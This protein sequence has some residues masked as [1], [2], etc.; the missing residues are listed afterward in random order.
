LRIT[1]ATM[2][3]L[4]GAS[5]VDLAWL[6]RG[7]E[8]L[9]KSLYTVD[10]TMT[11]FHPHPNTLPWPVLLLFGCYSR[12]HQF[13]SAK[14]IDLAKASHAVRE[15]CTRIRWWAHFVDDPD[16][17]PNNTNAHAVKSNGIDCMKNVHGKSSDI[18]PPRADTALQRTVVYKPLVPRGPKGF[19]GRSAPEINAVCSSLHNGFMKHVVQVN[20]KIAHK[21]LAGSN[22]PWYARFAL[23]FI[24]KQNLCAI[25]SDK[26]GVFTILHR[27]TLQSMTSK[28]VNSSKY[29]EVSLKQVE[30]EKMNAIPHAHKIC[31][32]MNKLGWKRWA[33]DARYP[34]NNKT[35]NFTYKFRHTI[36]THKPEKQVVCR[37]LHTAAGHSLS[38][39]SAVIDKL[40]SE[41]LKPIE[42]LVHNTADLLK[43]VGAKKFTKGCMFLKL[44]VKD[45]YM[46]GNH[47]TIIDI[48][49]QGYKGA[50]KEFVIQV[51]SF[52]L[53]YQ[54]VHDTDADKYYQV[55]E[56]TGM[57]ARHSGALA[58]YV[59]YRLVERDFVGTDAANNMGIQLY[60]RFRD[61]ILVILTTHRYGLVVYEHITSKASQCYVVERDSFSLVGTAMLD[62]FIYKPAEFEGRLQWKPYVK[63]TANHVPLHWSSS[64][65]ASTHCTWPKTEMARMHRLS[66]SRQDFV[67]AKAAKIAR[68][69]YFFMPRPIVEAC[70][71]WSPIVRSELAAKFVQCKNNQE[72]A[73]GRVARIVLPYHPVLARGLNEV[74]KRVLDKWIQILRM[75]FGSTFTIK[76]AYANAGSPLHV[77]ARH[78]QFN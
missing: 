75:R 11:A 30:V 2:R 21:G 78:L 37:L 43:M 56:G 45:F 67:E 47:S 15:L 9:C 60:A 3:L 39:I 70:K 10:N 34:I 48:C 58:D 77:V 26:D 32:T 53:H 35:R 71:S 17:V 6:C 14:R 19:E 76:V 1:R 25:P 18:E 41:L 74:F 28:Q 8:V 13:R 33:T 7:P 38:G 69:T 54:F 40:Y 73:C 65:P 68:Y 64:H 23:K 4:R 62:T 36:K 22:I 66:L 42:H 49:A 51:L 59:F 57:G 31:S 46:S 63:P 55:L 12:K 72:D 50:D 5:T 27:D 24:K 61:D 44:D 16:T 52:I 29:S 20:R